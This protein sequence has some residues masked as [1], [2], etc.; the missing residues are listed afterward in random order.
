MR[1]TPIVNIIRQRDVLQEFP[2]RTEADLYL[3]LCRV[4]EELKAHYGDHVLMEEAADDLALRFS[5]TRLPALRFKKAARWMAETVVNR[6]TG[7]WR[8]SRQALRRNRTAK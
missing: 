4:Q 3:W 2:G 1:Y 6:G 5:E 8:A 7:W